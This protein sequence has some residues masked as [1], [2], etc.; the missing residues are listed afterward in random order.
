MKN[1]PK[2]SKFLSSHGLKHRISSST[3]ADQLSLDRIHDDSL[4]YYSDFVSE[5]V[6]L[7]E[8]FI[9]KKG[10]LPVLTASK[11][12][13]V[14]KEFELVDLLLSQ[15]ESMNAMNRRKTLITLQYALEN[16]D[17]NQ[18]KSS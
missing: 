18:V 15:L 17:I 11:L 4:L 16:A 8:Q 2:L 7:L 12:P 6:K 14:I 5:L 3:K 1:D 13:W 10:G 9:E